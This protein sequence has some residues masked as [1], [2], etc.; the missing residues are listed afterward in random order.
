MMIVKYKSKRGKK[1][2][3]AWEW[4]VRLEREWSGNWGMKKKIIKDKNMKSGTDEKRRKKQRRRTKEEMQNKKK[5]EN[6]KDDRNK[7]RKG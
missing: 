6:L 7:M 1:A 3:I 5:K 2:N 4:E